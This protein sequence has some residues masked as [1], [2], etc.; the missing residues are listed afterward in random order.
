VAAAVALVIDCNPTFGRVEF[1]ARLVHQPASQPASHEPT[2]W[3]FPFPPSAGPVRFRAVSNYPVEIWSAAIWEHLIIHLIKMVINKCI[4]KDR[5]KVKEKMPLSEYS[6][7][8]HTQWRLRVISLH[9]FARRLV[10]F[11]HVQ[12]VETAH[13][14]RVII[15]SSLLIARF[16][17]PRYVVQ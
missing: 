7:K 12:V 14:T 8:I 10:L 3:V 1:S 2:S 9:N 6:K 17:K 13:L 4:T 16:H 5:G 15:I 11:P